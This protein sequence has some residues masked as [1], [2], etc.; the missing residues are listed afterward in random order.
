MKNWKFYLFLI[1]LILIT[2]WVFSKFIFISEA[3]RVWWVIKYGARAIEN[4]DLYR[5]LGIIAPDYYDDFGFDYEK[6][7]NWLKSQFA[8]YDE[9]DVDIITKKV[10]VKEENAI[11]SLRVNLYGKIGNEYGLIYGRGFGGDVLIL[12]LKKVNNNWL[13]IR[14]SPG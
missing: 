14:S 10:R 13:V 6:V 2:I 11:C 4:E 5:C 3:E 9:L 8:Q 12:Y 7:R 1:I